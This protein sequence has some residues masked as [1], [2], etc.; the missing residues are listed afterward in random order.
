MQITGRAG[1]DDLAL[2]LAAAYQQATEWHSK[3]PPV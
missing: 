1:Q 3:R 2:A